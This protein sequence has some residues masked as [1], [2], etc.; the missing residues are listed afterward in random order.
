MNKYLIP[1][2]LVLFT[3]CIGTKTIHQGDKSI[4]ISQSKT[5]SFYGWM[6]DDND[7]YEIDTKRIEQLFAAELKERGLEYKESGGDII[8]S[9]FVVLEKDAT[10]N[11]YS[12]FYNVG[13]YGFITPTWGWGVGNY[14]PYMNLSDPYYAG[15]PYRENA[16][17]RGT[18]VCNVFDMK[19][20]KLAWQGIYSKALNPD[21][22]PKKNYGEKL[23]K[24]IMRTFPVQ[25]E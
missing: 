8:F 1:F 23:V 17:L 11:R 18:L 3:S 25:A 9:L 2:A 15:V 19:T 6:G 24:H 12:S 10:S 20:K 14:T 4:D 7:D 16:Y 5:Y 22:A 21:A 13:P